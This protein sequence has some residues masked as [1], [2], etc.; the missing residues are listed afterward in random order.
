MASNNAPATREKATTEERAATEFFANMPNS[1]FIPIICHHSLMVK[2]S[3]Y[4]SQM[5][6]IRT[7]T[8]TERLALQTQ[9]W[10]LFEVI[11]ILRYICHSLRLLLIKNHRL[12]HIVKFVK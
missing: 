5:R 1:N 8:I 4:S 7:N 10:F 9:L 12:K 11:I 6:V 2:K 3:T